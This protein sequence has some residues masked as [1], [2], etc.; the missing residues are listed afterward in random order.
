MILFLTH[1][2]LDAVGAIILS[3]YFELKID[4]YITTDYESLEKDIDL[5]DE[6]LK[7]NKII[8]VDLSLPLELYKKIVKA[9]KEYLVFDHHDPTKQY[10]DDPNVYWDNAF[11]GTM[12]FFRYLRANK[13]LPSVV[14]DFL[15]LVDT[16][17]MWRKKSPLWEDAQNLNRILWKNTIYQCKGEAKYKTFISIQL[18]KLNKKVDEFY[19]TD[20]ER[21][22][23]KE[24]RY[25]ENNAVNKAR[26]ILKIRTD[27]KGYKFGLI[28]ASSKISLICSKLLEEN[29]DIIYI[30]AINSYRGINGKLSVRARENSEYDCNWLTDI[31]GHK[32]S[33]GGNITKDDTLKLWEGCIHELEYEY[34]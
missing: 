26:K 32:L 28:M 24:A 8:I 1:I 29:P 20:P 17:D 3:K 6:I 9:N 2:D 21:Y 25:E 12:I 22:D 31:K 10:K 11:S 15:E 14:H 23:I 4:K 30:I 18:S 34:N 5:H 16:F 27:K 19:L 7:Y 33:G 13:R